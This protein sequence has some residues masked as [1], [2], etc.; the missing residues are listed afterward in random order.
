M[1]KPARARNLIGI[2]VATC[3]VAGLWLQVF[4]M[5]GLLWWNAPVAAR[6]VAR[7]PVPPLPPVQTDWVDVDAYLRNHPVWVQ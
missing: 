3:I 4:A 2:L 1:E 5:T 7:P 6:P